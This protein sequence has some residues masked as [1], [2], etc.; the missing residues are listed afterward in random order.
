MKKQKTFIFV[1]LLTALIYP[2]FGQNASL[3]GTIETPTGTI[4]SN[5]EVRLLDAGGALISAQTTN[6][7]Q[8]TFDNLT[9]GD[10]YQLEMIKDS[11]PLNG[12]STFDVVLAARHILGITL[13][14]TPEK[15]LA[16]D[17]NVNGTLTTLDL[18]LSRRLILAIDQNFP[19]LPSWRFISA[20]L[21]LTQPGNTPNDNNIVS[22][23]LNNAAVIQDITGI[24]LGDLNNS[25]VP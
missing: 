17:V 25:V 23:T 15:L 12:V 6:N 16:A 21:D 11:Y 1:F 19:V 4:V 5:V 24:K 10:T 22:V 3:S 18:V 7:G 14:D 8:Y 20:D 9:Q 13:L 2:L